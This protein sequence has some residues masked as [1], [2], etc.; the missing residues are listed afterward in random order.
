MSAFL[1]DINLVVLAFRTFYQLPPSL[2]AEEE[3][4]P[5]QEEES[6]LKFSTN[7]T[8]QTP[9]LPAYSISSFEMFLINHAPVKTFVVF[10]YHY[11]DSL[12]YW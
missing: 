7:N 4:F 12:F 9:L 1:L 2:Q 8:P 11:I 3:A 5:Y 6:K 10:V